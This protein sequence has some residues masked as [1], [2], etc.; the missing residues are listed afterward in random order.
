MQSE[1][2]N[3]EQLNSMLDANEKILHESTREADRVME[4][5]KR[6]ELPS[7]D[8]V[9]VAPTVVGEQLYKLVADERST[10][11]ALF[12]LTRALDKGRISAEVFIKQ[13][14]SLA[15]E[16]FLQKALI[17]KIGRGMNLAMDDV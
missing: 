4:N 11:D 1:K 14:R 13:T 5:V 6:K 9:L 8:D 16:Q 15:R 12:A 3:L 2:Y 17:K 7:V 10:A